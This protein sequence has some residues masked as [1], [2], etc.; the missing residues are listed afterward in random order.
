MDYSQRHVLDE[1]YPSF[2]GDNLPGMTVEHS[3]PIDLAV[4][5]LFPDLN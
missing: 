3:F 5:I 4:K 1:I 2:V